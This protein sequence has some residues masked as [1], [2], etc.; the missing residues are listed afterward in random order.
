MS[1]SLVSTNACICTNATFSAYSEPVPTRGPGRLWRSVIWRPS[2]PST[3]VRNSLHHECEELRLRVVGHHC[4]TRNKRQYGGI[5]KAAEH[6]GLKAGKPAAS[7]RG[8]HRGV[9]RL[10]VHAIFDVWAD[11]QTPDCASTLPCATASASA[12]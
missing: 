8:P 3:K 1:S 10:E 4:A 5:G 2:G 12:A 6:C 11:D 9:V 7:D